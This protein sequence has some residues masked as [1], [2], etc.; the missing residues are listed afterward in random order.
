MHMFYIT[1]ALV[2][3]IPMSVMAWLLIR[4]ELQLRSEDKILSQTIDAQVLGIRIKP[5][6]IGEFRTEL[7]R[8]VRR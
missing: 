6:K 8:S 2:W 4:L 3:L 5:I 1:L 7:I